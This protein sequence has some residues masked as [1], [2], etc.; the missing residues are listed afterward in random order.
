M[1]LSKHWTPFA[2]RHPLLVGCFF[3]C[4]GTAFTFTS[5]A[6]VSVDLHGW[7]ALLH[8]VLILLGLETTYRGIAHIEDY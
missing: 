2:N 6:F 1:I 5:G 8:P 4:L 3:L 7:G